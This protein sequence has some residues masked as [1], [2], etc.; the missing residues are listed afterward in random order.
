MIECDYNKP[1]SVLR[2]FFVEM[3]A[4]DL[5][6][7]RLMKS[8]P[9]NADYSAKDGIFEQAL[10]EIN[11]IFEKYCTPKERKQGRQN[12]IGFSSPLTYDLATQPI[13]EINYESPRRAVVDTFDQIRKYA[14]GGF[15]AS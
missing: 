13:S 9:E 8:L 5:H 15:Y 10:A 1:E 14:A 2:A 7:E 11:R 3:N 6:F 12:W 4:W